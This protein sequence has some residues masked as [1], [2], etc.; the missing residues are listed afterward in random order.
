MIFGD[1]VRKAQ[2][3]NFDDN[4]VLC[5]DP[6]TGE[7]IAIGGRH[8]ESC[9]DGDDLEAIRNFCLA[10]TPGNNEVA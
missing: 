9:L 10:V 5:I 4:I 2:H 1:R 6:L 3:F 8:L 7:L